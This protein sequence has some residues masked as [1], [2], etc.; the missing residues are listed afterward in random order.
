MWLKR[1]NLCVLFSSFLLAFFPLHSSFFGENCTWIWANV[2]QLLW[3]MCKAFRPSAKACDFRDRSR[4]RVRA[5]RRLRFRFRVRVR[6]R[7]RVRNEGMLHYSFM[8]MHPCSK[9]GAVRIMAFRSR[10]CTCIW[11]AFTR[12]PGWTALFIPSVEAQHLLRRLVVHEWYWRLL[13]VPALLWT[14]QVNALFLRVNEWFENRSIP[15]LCWGADMFSPQQE[16]FSGQ[17]WQRHA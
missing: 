4:F 1:L 12:I 11:A 2:M 10:D 14:G 3:V 5:R 8:Y 9:T 6:V 16:L 17:T 13:L 7:V 15:Q